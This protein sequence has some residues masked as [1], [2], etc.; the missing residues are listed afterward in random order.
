MGE[1]IGYVRVS[2]EDQHTARQED[3]MKQLGVNRMFIDK[4][5]GKD[6]NRHE[7]KKMMNFIRE[8][9]TVIVESISRL[10]RSTKD[11]LTIIEEFDKK[12]VH[13]I[14]KKESIDTQTPTGKFM[15]TVFA[16]LYELERENIHER[17]A[18]G[19]AAAKRRGKTFGRPA[20][21]VD[22]QH[23]EEIYKRWKDKDITAV[24]AMKALGLKKATFY[25]KVK[26]YE[27]RTE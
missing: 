23:F 21:K 5:S 11:F 26:E 15:M 17:Q 19:I 16:A 18:E 20:V 4:C 1:K 10:A 8:G 25:R 12:K 2:S 24:A 9:D 7:L 22:Q 6:M 14:S 3:M 27:G 13:F